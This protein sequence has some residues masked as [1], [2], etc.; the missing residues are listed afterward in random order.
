MEDTL[1]KIAQKNILADNDMLTDKIIEKVLGPEVDYTCYEYN[2]QLY[3]LIVFIDRKIT[4]C[5]A[6]VLHSLNGID[7]LDI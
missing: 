4:R 1:M 5:K 3:N 7:F 6:E 2:L